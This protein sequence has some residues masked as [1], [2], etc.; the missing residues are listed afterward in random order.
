MDDI[1]FVTTFNRKLYDATGRRMIKT[2]NGTQPYKLMIGAEGMAEDEIPACPK[3]IYRNID[4]SELLLTWLDSNKDIIPV[5]YG[6]TYTCKCRGKHGGRCANNMMRRRTSHWF[7]KIVVLEEALKL[8]ATKV[9]FTDCDTVYAKEIPVD[10]L[11]GLF[12][13]VAVFYHYGS[14]RKRA[15]HGIETGIFGLNL[16]C[17]GLDVFNEIVR[18]YKNGE[19]RK[20]HRWDDAWM[21]TEVVGQMNRLSFRDVVEGCEK[22]NTHVVPFGPF[23]KYIKHKKGVHRVRL[24]V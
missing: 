9:V 8:A 16:E 17:G 22:H 21:M 11:N 3:F 23:G 6:G 7:R 13:D 5:E 19:F 10:V 20:Y 2:F 24:G 18:Q 14:Y 15:G 1:L 4:N 12:D